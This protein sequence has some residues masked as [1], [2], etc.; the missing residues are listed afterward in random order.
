MRAGEKGTSP[1]RRIA[2]WERDITAPA[3]LTP[4][5][6]LGAER[7][8]VR[9]GIPERSPACP[10]HPPTAPPW[11][12]LSPPLRAERDSWHGRGLPGS[13]RRL[14]GG[15]GTGDVQE[16]LFEI[17][18]AVAVDQ[19]AWAA[20]IDD[21]AGLHHPGFRAQPLDLGHV[22]RGKDDRRAGA[23]PVLFKVAAHP[24]AG[25]GIERHGRLVE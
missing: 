24:I 17:G 16:H 21:P 12:P 5:P 23:G 18:A 22:V 8:G 6:P 25:V 13:L 15:A 3:P 2:R 4:S 10:P 7:A 1:A 20:A 19:R 9:W 14:Q 11:A